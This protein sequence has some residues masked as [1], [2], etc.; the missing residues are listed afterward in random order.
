MTDFIGFKQSDD[1]RC[2][3][4]AV[5]SVLYYYGIDK[6]E[7]EIAKRCNH[8]YELGCSNED[9]VKALKHF[10][11]GAKIYTNSTL[12]DLEYWTRHKTPVIV[13]VFMGTLETSATGH[14]VVVTGV[15]KKY[16]HVYDP[17]VNKNISV[18]RVDFLRMWFDWENTEYIQPNTKMIIRLMI[19]PYPI[20]LDIKK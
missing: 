15:D 11:V 3:V 16:V 7:D 14:A 12:E 13:D 1:S 9:M 5:K 2:G 20:R 17:Y 4:A 19:V 6:T 8:S 18:D 10:G